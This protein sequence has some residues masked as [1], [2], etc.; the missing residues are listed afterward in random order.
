MRRFAKAGQAMTDKLGDI[1]DVVQ[2][3]IR[4]KILGVKPG[5]MGQ[6]SPLPEKGPFRAVRRGLANTVFAPRAGNQYDF[7][8]PY[9]NNRAGV[10]AM[11]GMRALQAGAVTGSGVALANLTTALGQQNGAN[12]QSDTQLRM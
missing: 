3:M 2:D 5:M 11:L 6:S 9:E 4:S 10:A 12:Q 1:D 7:T 8:S